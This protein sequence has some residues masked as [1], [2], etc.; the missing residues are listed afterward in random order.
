M[1]SSYVR[2]AND[3]AGKDLLVLPH[4]TMWQ[5]GV[6]A[7]EW[8]H[9]EIHEGD[10]FSFQEVIT[11]GSAATQDYLIT[12]AD[13]TKWPHFGWIIEGIAGVTVELFEGTTHTGGT[14]QTA[15]DRNRN[16]A[17]TPGMTIHKGPSGGADGT[18]IAW[19]KSGSGTSSGKLSGTSIEIAERVL[20]Q[21]TKYLLRVTSAA[22][23][24]DINVVFNWYEHTNP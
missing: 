24:N 10:S 6:V 20:K 16:T 23:S 1:S 13:T 3:A 21:N 7:T 2:I 9:H 19:R 14:P 12:V 11:L 22:A 15:Y 8:E 18:K 5:Q 17:N 4:G